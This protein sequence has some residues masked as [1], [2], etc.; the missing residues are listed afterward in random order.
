MPDGGEVTESEREL[1][2]Q[3][4]DAVTVVDRS[5]HYRFVSRGA[6]AIIGRLPEELV[7]SYVWDV[8]PDV[9]GSAEYDS[10]QRAMTERVAVRFVWLHEPSRRWLEQHAI[11][12]GDGLVFVVDD[13]T[14][15]EV[16]IRRSEQLVKVGEALAR[17]TTY[18]EV[19]AAV[20][21]F[22]L[23]SVGASGGGIVLVDHARGVVR[24]LGWEGLDAET[25]DRWV[26]FPLDVATPSTEAIRTGSPVW[27]EGESTAR[28]RYPDIAADL[29][30][31]G[32]ETVA[33]LPLT[34]AGDVLGALVLTF[35]GGRRLLPQDSDFLAT[36]AAMCA[37]AIAR[38]RLFDIEKRTIDALQRSLLPRDLPTVEGLDVTVRYASSEAGA[39]I[40]GDWYD[41]I[42]LPSGAV[43]LVLGDV[44]GHD[45]G[46]AALMGLVRSA[47]RAYTIDDHPPAVIL[48]R[49][50]EF[51]AGLAI[52]RIVT[53]AYLVLHPQ[54]RVV[55][56]VSAGHPAAVMLAPG[57][58][59][60]QVPSETGPPLG[61]VSDGLSWAETTS[62]L[63]A[64]ATVTMF[65]DGLFERRDED[66][67][68]SLARVSDTLDAT[69]ALG[70]E[71]VADAL[72]ASRR[73]RLVDDM[74]LLVVR[75][76]VNAED[77]E[78]RVTRRLP[79]RPASVTLARRFCRQLLQA[80]QVDRATAL[81]AELV[82]SELVTN[83]ARHSEEPIEV[84][85]SCPGQVLRIEV[86]DSSHRLPR[87]D[88]DLEDQPTAGR[89][90]RIVEELTSR[91]G[92]DSYGLSKSVWCEFDLPPRRR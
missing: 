32:V 36:V 82:A 70:V 40:G 33:A 85:L 62:L 34:I 92:V 89:G 80:W 57:H 10:V 26:E 65:S 66:L 51:L 15:R 17:T 21:E 61:V 49:T 5:W 75:V 3:L 13:V 76:T 86:L 6:A 90:L 56:A 7:G 63:P 20:A 30:R 87:T 31:L 2:E 84:A 45:L 24:A 54:E 73:G 52:S 23:P 9:V 50:N 37:Q 28:A 29:T 43:A 48:Q 11:P 16:G 79:P 19:R 59:P 67:D 88:G 39:D 72:V 64:E 53:V 1:F 69:R 42:P 38:A 18:G 77:R 58:A 27:V 41:V 71:D 35:P 4:A 22:A 81:D 25:S 68:V 83:A 60:F 12:V 74:A 14:E 78:R 55:T 8:F 91:W 47:V 44:E 46:A